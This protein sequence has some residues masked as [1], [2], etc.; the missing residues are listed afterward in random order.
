[1]VE[2]RW[3]VEWACGL[4]GGGARSEWCGAGRCTPD[5]LAASRSDLVH[6]SMKRGSSL[7]PRAFASR[8]RSRLVLSSCSLAPPKRDRDSYG[9]AQRSVGTSLACSHERAPV[10]RTY[11]WGRVRHARRFRN[12]SCERPRN[13]LGN[14]CA[15]ESVKRGWT[16]I[17]GVRRKTCPLR[18]K[19][20]ERTR[21]SD[22]AIGGPKFLDVS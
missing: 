2:R 6:R 21:H 3:G 15:G 10:A 14:G 13:G 1:M 19:L 9:H 7:G 17:R 11:M 22:R 4:R 12:A 16:C 20:Q 18:R 5:P 8:P